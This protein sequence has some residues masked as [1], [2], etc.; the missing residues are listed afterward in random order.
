[1][2]DY[3]EKISALAVLLKSNSPNF[4]LSG[5]GISTESGIEDF[6]SPGTG[7]WTKIDPMKYGTVSFLKKDP[8]TFYDVNL[9][10]WRRFDVQPN[11]A[12]IA[13][14]GLENKGLIVGVITQN[15][16]GLHTRAGSHRIWEVH[17]H[18][19][20]CHC[21]RCGEVYPMQVLFNKYDS[22]E[23][24]PLCSGCGSFLRPDVVL[25][26]D[27]MSE[28]FF[29]AEMALTGCQ[30]LVV[31]GSSL[32]VYPVAA[33]PERCRHLVIINR[34]ETPW[35]DRAEIVINESL[36]KVFNDL[37]SCLS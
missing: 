17:G 25:F 15:I 9:K 31:A 22:G 27:P 10:W 29:K 1:M 2:S 19:R 11:D 37:M 20:T 4:V 18:L 28:D 5:A 16:D 8:A 14:A 7:L 33:L 13:V 35:D 23:N 24:P 26:E 30:V 12:H 3:N 34:E 21:I 32:Q 36:G 6:R